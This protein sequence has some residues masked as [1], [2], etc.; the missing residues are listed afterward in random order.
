MPEQPRSILKNAPPLGSYDSISHDSGTDDF[1]R[2]AVLENTRA[3]AQLNDVGST[4]RR[5]STGEGSG[6]SRKNSFSTDSAGSQEQGP[7]DHL[8]WDEANLY[9]A[10]QEKNATMKIT[11]PKTPYQGAVGDSEYYMP[12]EEEENVKTRD[13]TVLNVDELDGFSLGEAEVSAPSRHL[14]EEDRIIPSP[15]LNLEGA[16]LD[17]AEEEMEET[18]EQKHKRFEVMRKSHY[19]MKGAVLKHPLQ[20]DEDDDEDEDEE[21]VPYEDDYDEDDEDYHDH[22]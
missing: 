19:H 15:E 22:N 12:D 16:K 13:N 18:P 10:E 8:K 14:A 3:N 7:Q 21:T 2:T 1:D 20:V 4:I 9:L 5:V 17:Q 6:P 11:E